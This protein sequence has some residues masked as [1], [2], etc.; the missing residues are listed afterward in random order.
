VLIRTYA[1]RDNAARAAKAQWE[2]LQR[3]VAT[4]SLQLDEGRADLYTEMPVKV[5]EFK[6]QI[7]EAEWVITTLTHTVS[8]DGGFMTS[9]EMEVMINQQP[10]IDWVIHVSL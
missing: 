7:D 9:I 2:K 8:S 3:G 1:S 4:F 5:T 6:Q 10:I